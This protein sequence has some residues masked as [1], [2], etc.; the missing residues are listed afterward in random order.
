MTPRELALSKSPRKE[1][2]VK[3]LDGN[4]EDVNVKVCTN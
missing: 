1:R 3:I 2:I 4:F